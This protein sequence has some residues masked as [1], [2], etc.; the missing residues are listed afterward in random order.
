MVVHSAHLRPQGSARFTTET[1]YCARLAARRMDLEEVVDV[2]VL[3]RNQVVLVGRVAA[4]PEERTLPSGDVLLLWRLVVDRP[5]PRRAAP[6]G[7]R[8]PTV[9]TLDCVAWAAGVRRSASSFCTGDVVSVEGS[10]RRRFWRDG[11]GAVSRY[12]VEAHKV[13]R[14]QRAA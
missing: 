2:D 4:V 8:M 6:E 1:A 11:A 12:E 5:P 13:K 9:D 7:V 14:L 10:L 3:G